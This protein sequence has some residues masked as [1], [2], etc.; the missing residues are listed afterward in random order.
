[1][2][3]RCGIGMVRRTLFMLNLYNKVQLFIENGYGGIN[4][5]NLGYSFLY[6]DYSNTLYEFFHMMYLLCK[7][8]YRLRD[9]KCENL[10]LLPFSCEI[11]PGTILTFSRFTNEWKLEESLLRRQG[12]HEKVLQRDR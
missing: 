1:M 4:V 9:G 7:Q 5:I 3:V 11:P 10:C 8:L 12:L 2:A 6:D